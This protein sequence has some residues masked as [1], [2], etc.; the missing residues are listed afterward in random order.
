[1]LP[2]FIFCALM[3]QGNSSEPNLLNIRQLTFGGQNAEAYWSVD[4][5]SLTLQTTQPQWV[6]EQIVKVDV[7]T[8]NQTLI[9]T[10]MGRCTCAYYTPDK[11]YIYFSSTHEKQPGAQPPIDMSKGYVWMVNPNMS[12][13]RTDSNGKNIKK[14]IDKGTYV[15][16]TTIAPNGKYMVWTSDFEGDLE[17]YRSDLDGKHIKR[18]TNKLGYDGGPFV[19]WDSKKI[20]YRR[21]APMTPDQEKEYK[22]LL[23]EH[24][25][26]PSKMDI[27]IMDADGTNKRQV[28][29]LPGASFAP[30][31]HPDG[32]RVVFSSN[33]E[34]PKGREF[35]IYIVNTDGKNLRSV[36]TTPEFDGFP[37]FT[38]DGKQLVFAS[39]RNGKVRGETNIFVADWKE[40][41]P[42]IVPAVPII[43]PLRK[44][45]ATA[46]DDAIRLEATDD[47]WVYPF[48]QEQ[49]KDEYMRI[50]GTGTASIPEKGTDEPEQSYSIARFD[51]SKLP[52]GKV[53]SAKLELTLIAKD[54]LTQSVLE[55][56]PLEVHAVNGDFAEKSWDFGKVKSFLPSQEILGSSKDWALQ[57]DKPCKVEVNLLGGPGDFQKELDAARAK[58]YLGLALASKLPA[59]ELGRDG[60]YKFYSR[61]SSSKSGPVLRL[62]IGD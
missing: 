40:A 53:K 15:A 39:N 43:P 22:S 38:R 20:V 16:E 34:D 23:K 51:V 50:W 8:G 7:A 26:R 12:L 60:I 59:A 37:M 10:G 48:A 17:I 41:A 54:V 45:Q 2:T 33:W 61:N 21:T 28:T 57:F 49:E 11:K 62:E 35:N 44:P 46:F 24:L 3:G 18:L 4:G 31:L 19:S 9:S 1:M 55:K 5:K 42:K 14:L 52:T 6:D 36:T 27:W 56:Y 13:Y 47:V 32:K 29:N 25:V 58:G 30:F